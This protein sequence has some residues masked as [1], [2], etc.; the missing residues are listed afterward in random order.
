MQIQITIPQEKLNIIID[1]LVD[2]GDDPDLIQAAG[3]EIDTVRSQAI[4][5]PLLQKTVSAWF[6]K[7]AD[8]MIISYSD[9]ISDDVQIPAIKQAR[10]RLDAA[11]ESYYTVERI[12][13][14]AVQRAI[15]LLTQQGYRV[16]K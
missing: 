8:Y 1:N 12:Q 5:D 9:E 15:Q 3:L 11:S 16:E 2:F 4:N 7:N 6:N 10:D 14:E 13:Q